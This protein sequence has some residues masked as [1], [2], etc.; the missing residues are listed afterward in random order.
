VFTLQAFISTSYKRK[1]LPG[2]IMPARLKSKITRRQLI[3]QTTAT[4]QGSVETK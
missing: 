4:T 3:Q 1:A 2:K